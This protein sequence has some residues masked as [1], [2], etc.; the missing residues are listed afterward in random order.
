F[1]S[2]SDSSLRKAGSPSAAK[3]SRTV[4]PVCTSMYSSLSTMGQLKTHA[5]SRP[6]V[7][8]PVP[9]IPTRTR[10]LLMEGIEVALQLVDGVAP[11]LADQLVR[12]HERDHGFRDDAH[13]RHRRDVGPF[14]EA[15]RLLFG[16]DVDRLQ[17]RT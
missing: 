2:T 12:E 14:L 17:H 10:F 3:M 4:F 7:V 8:F 13:R 6:T 9:I 1:N 15:D 11:E 16:D 5:M